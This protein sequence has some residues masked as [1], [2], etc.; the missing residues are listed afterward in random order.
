MQN[1]QYQELEKEL[2][3]KLKGEVS[4]EQDYRALYA[5]DASN[6]R[7]I[8]VGVVFPKD[9]EDILK[10]VELCHKHDLHLLT[11]GGGTSLAGQCCNDGLIMDF[12]KYYN[13]ILEIDPEK[14][15]A[16]VQT[17]LVLDDLN[18]ALEEHGLIFGP[19]P[20]THNHCTMGGM[21]GNN[22]CGIHSVMA[23]VEDG[24]IRT[25]DFVESMELLTYDGKVFEAGQTSDEELEKIIKS[26]KPQSEIYAKLKELRDEF[27]EDIREGI[28][29]LPR[30]VSGYNL[31][32][33]LPEKGFNVAR[34]LVG[35]EST[36]VVFLEATL[37]LITAP[38]KRSLLILGYDSVY[39]AGD[40][41][42]SIMK[43]KPIGLEGLDKNLITY[44]HKRH[45][46]EEKLSLLPEGEGWLM[47]EFG[48]RNKKESDEKAKKL[49]ADLK[50][51]NSKDYP[52]MELYEDEEREHA[53]WEIRESGLGA[54][55][56]VQGLPD[57]WT[58]WEDSAVPPVKV[59]EYLRDLRKLFQKYGYNPALYGH[60]GQ[61][62]IHC[63]IGFDLKTKGGIDDYLKFTEEAADL[64]VS[65][66][67]SLSGEHGD[68]QS[69]GPLLYKMYGE[70]LMNAFHK[71]KEI[72]DP[73]WKMN[74]GK[75]IDPLPRN[76]N[77]RMGKDF[78]PKD[79]KKTYFKFPEDQGS[80][81]RAA[82][83]CVGVG[84]CRK[85]ETGTMCPSYMV[86]RDEKNVTRG[87]AHLLFELMRGKELDD[88]FRNEKVKESLDLCL[89]CKGCLGECPVH[90]DMATYKAEFLAHYYKNR[91]RPRSAYAFGYIDKWAEM[92]S[93]ATAPVNFLSQHETFARIV[94]SFGAI[95]PQREIPKFAEKTFKQ[96]HQNPENVDWSRAVLLWPDTFNNNFYPEVLNSAKEILENAGF[97]V[98]TP[99]KHYCCGRPLYDFGM[100]DEAKSYLQKILTKLSDVIQAG[101][102]FV[103]LEASCIAVFRNELKNLFPNDNNAKRLHQSFK[104]LPEFILEN[105][106][107]FEFHK[108][109]KT[110]LLQKHCHHDAVMGYDADME[111]FKRAG[112]DVNAP[113]SGCCGL[114]GSF[115]FEK[116]EKY[117]ISMK[118]GE[119]RILPM[120]RKMTEDYLITDGFSCREQIQHGAGRLPKHPVEIL[121]AALT[122]KKK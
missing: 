62:C 19:D 54:T 5:T 88:G 30:R 92:A 34:S 111:V 1:D 33:L 12:S 65:Y 49:M 13:K 31:D 121:A 70:R 90:V 55:A 100:L 26:D 103:G 114:A 25:S 82:M 32:D 77:L 95:A 45:L 104:T 107:K 84:E 6:Y 7:Q 106:D 69:R 80:F 72:W 118:V 73:N 61:G 50:D 119:R 52:R 43:H 117:D 3:E 85:T 96:Q 21:M 108:L 105:E 122:N 22:S 102:P 18:R 98:I 20:A 83:R 11:R 24:G 64:V 67:G 53:V 48:G 17:G 109:N 46:H 120:V 28:P 87:R 41:V 81:H 99:T 51:K 113:D 75:V 68:G 101:V 29:D 39:E 9:K 78:Y 15:T 63:R 35:T 93:K 16:R 76:E 40:H 116:G 79:P 14:K 8:P 44:M 115:G 36:C 97:V 86:T 2:K 42:E 60:F 38:K 91:P 27:E 56:F 47:V 71:F 89:A 23:Q 59:G 57:M 94:K 10:T 110:A 66:G 37:R 112:V 58:G 4:F 74:P